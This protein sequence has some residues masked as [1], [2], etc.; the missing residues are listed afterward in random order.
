MLLFHIKSAL[1]LRPTC[2]NRSVMVLQKLFSSSHQNTLIQATTICY[3]IAR[4]TFVAVLP[5]LIQRCR[6]FS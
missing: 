6:L 1:G 2:T 4:A 3:H 5:Y